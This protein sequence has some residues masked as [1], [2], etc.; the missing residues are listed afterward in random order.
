MKLTEEEASSMN[1]DQRLSAAYLKVH[2]KALQNV[3]ERHLFNRASCIL[4]DLFNAM[5]FL[6]KSI[7]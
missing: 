4:G 2:K 6:L 7:S 1:Q 5:D 3:L